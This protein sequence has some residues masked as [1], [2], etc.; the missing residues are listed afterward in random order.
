[1]TNEEAIFCLNTTDVIKGEKKK[2]KR[3]Y[4]NINWS[5]KQSHIDLVGIYYS[6]QKMIII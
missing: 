3:K 2:R 5:Y 1:M 4:L 6:D